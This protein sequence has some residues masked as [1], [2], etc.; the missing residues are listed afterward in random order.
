MAKI[1][2]NKLLQE[3]K[4]LFHHY[5]PDLKINDTSLEDNNSYF[6]LQFRLEEFIAIHI[7]IDLMDSLLEFFFIRL[8][9]DGNLFPSYGVDTKGKPIRFYFSQIFNYLKIQFDKKKRS[10]DFQLPSNFYLQDN[11]NDFLL[12]KI[13]D[14]LLFFAPILNNEQSI[15]SELQKTETWERIK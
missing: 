2:K 5:F 10:P 4:N 15:L 11:S 3:T 12:Q 6:I 1:D 9:K 14:G 13:K 8:D 7:N